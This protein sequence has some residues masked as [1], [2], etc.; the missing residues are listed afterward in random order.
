MKKL[1]IAFA[2]LITMSVQIK[3][4]TKTTDFRTY[5]WG[6]LKNDLAQQEKLTYK[7]IPTENKN[8]LKYEDE[9][10]G[11]NCYVIY[12]FNDNDKLISG[13][14]ILRNH[15]SNS[16]LYLHDFAKYE[17]LLVEK[18][19]KV[20][21]LKYDW[22]ENKASTDKENF[23]QAIADGNLIMTSVWE[24]PR[25]VIKLTLFSVNEKPSLQIH[26]TYKTLSELENNTEL[27]KALIKL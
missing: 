3:A 18:Y 23:G 2:T 17:K 5:N 10:G 19:G 4:Q 11:A 14:Y 8:S 15:Y 12:T 26:Y 1:A 25:S 9:L 13:N 16:Q 21:T 22:I 6:I 7:N 24:T 27:K 20:T